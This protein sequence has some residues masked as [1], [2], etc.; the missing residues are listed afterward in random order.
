MARRVA[1]G[2]TGTG[3]LERMATQG[4]RPRGKGTPVRRNK[5]APA[6]RFPPPKPK[7]KTS[8]VV[9]DTPTPTEEPR[10]L[11]LF[12]GREAVGINVIKAKGY[13]T[14]SVADEI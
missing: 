12:N 7:K 2:L 14:T 9:F 1:R 13:S 3:T 4:R 5:A 8:K 6:E 11:A 10:T